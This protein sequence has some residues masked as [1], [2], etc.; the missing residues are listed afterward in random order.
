[1][2]HSSPEYQCSMMTPCTFTGKVIIERERLGREEDHLLW[3]RREKVRKALMKVVT[4]MLDKD[5]A[6]D[7]KFLNCL[8][9]NI[10]ILETM[11]Q[12]KEYDSQMICTALAR[13]LSGNI[14]LILFIMILCCLGIHVKYCQVMMCSSS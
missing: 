6:D 9:K 8:L 12:C 13:K 4:I 3:D 10:V 2:D 7:R 1:M 5:Y 11:E 14:R